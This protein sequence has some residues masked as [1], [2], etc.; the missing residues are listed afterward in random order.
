MT[1]DDLIK[2]LAECCTA[3]DLDDD[4]G[5]MS[6]LVNVVGTERAVEIAIKLGGILIYVPRRVK[7]KLMQKFVIKHYNGQNSRQLALQ[8]RVAERTVYRWA[9]ERPEVAGVKQGD[10]F[11]ED[12]S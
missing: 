12:E 10:L 3:E 9:R 7:V 5:S 8:L 1:E 4:E 2:K 6:F 11:N